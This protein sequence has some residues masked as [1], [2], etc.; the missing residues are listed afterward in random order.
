MKNTLMVAA[1]L[2]ALSLPMWAGSPDWDKDKHKRQE[3]VPEG[4][5][6]PAYTIVSGAALLGGLMLA[7][8]RQTGAVADKS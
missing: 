3:A 8:K 2:F 4:G 1:V 6:W 5:N 7:R